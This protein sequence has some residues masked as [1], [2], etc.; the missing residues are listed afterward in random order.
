MRSSR[1]SVGGA[2]YRGAMEKNDQVQRSARQATVVA[3]LAAVVFAGIAIYTA[4]QGNLIEAGGHTLVVC[5][6]LA[7]AY[8]AI[9]P[10]R[11]P[12]K[13]RRIMIAA[14]TLVPI[15]ILVFV[16]SWIF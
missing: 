8:L 1:W 16:L 15:T 11:D 3:V 6:A 9:D 7:T 10:L 14:L 5:L 4:V 13:Q 2:G 12:G